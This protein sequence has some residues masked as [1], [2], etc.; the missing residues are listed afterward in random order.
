MIECE[1]V[2]DCLVNTMKISG[3]DMKKEIDMMLEAIG[4]NEDQKQKWW[5]SPNH[6]FDRE[7][8]IEVFDT[9]PKQVYRYVHAHYSGGW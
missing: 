5:N 9:F 2:T 8:P 1:M 7:K 3:T 6:A 4:L